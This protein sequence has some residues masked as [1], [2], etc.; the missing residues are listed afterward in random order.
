MSA[1][2]GL[3]VL[4]FSRVLAGPLC[5]M[6]LADL[7]ADVVKVERPG[8]GDETRT[9]GP[10]FAGDD[11]A[12]FLSINRNKRS[13]ALDLSSEE[14]AR[15]ARAL[16]AGSD[17]LVENFR[18]GLMERFGLAYEQLRG[19]HPGLVYCSISA[20]GPEADPSRAGY[21]LVV[22]A[23]TGLMSVTGWPGG[24]PTKAGVALLDVAAGLY[25]AIGI[26]AA[27]E[28]RRQTGEGQRVSI[29]LFDAGVAAMVNQAANY[30]IGGE[31]PGRLGNEHPNIVP[32]QS[33]RA[34]DRPFV[35]AAGNDRLFRRACEVM[36]RPD[37]PEDPRF[38]T[39]D[40]RVRNRGTLIPVLAEIL[41]ARP[42]DD[43]LRG[44]AEAGV[45][46]A[47]IRDL[48]E[49]FDAPEGARLV[50]EVG[51]GAHGTLRLVA[52]PMRLSATPYEPRFPPPRLGEHTEEVLA[53][54]GEDPAS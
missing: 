28:A 24:E 13:V 11:A 7:G 47:P 19:E 37:L 27:L 34:A 3:R 29:S 30:L 26:L 39:N 16:A 35:L 14:G 44:F 22:Q 45:P 9:W 32:Y 25:A 49:V 17:V 15:A 36:G 46:A 52:S 21:D 23:L 43:W 38:A 18:P 10:P 12:Y 48:A 20:M 8:S 5:T 4:D 40:E 42:A 50:E 31:V 1:L 2:S 6:V 33:F 51:D 54:L 41:A 53:E